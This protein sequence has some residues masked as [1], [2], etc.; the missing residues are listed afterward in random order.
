MRRRSISA[1]I[2]NAALVAVAAEA[3]GQS[4]PGPTDA[5]VDQIAT[6]APVDAPD[7]N[8]DA[9]IDGGDLDALTPIDVPL[10]PLPDG[11][12]V[13]GKPD[14]PAPCGYTEDLNDFVACQIDHD[15]NTQE[16]AVCFVLCDPTEPDCI[17]YDLGDAGGSILTCG[18]GCIGRLR[19]DARD[20]FETCAPL[21]ESAA[22]F[23]ARAA[24]LEA[25]A[26]DAF[27]A[28]ARDLD[29]HGASHLAKRAR[30]AA[31]DEVRHARVTARLA[32]K[33]GAPDRRRCR[34]TGT[35]ADRAPRA[36][37][38]IAIENAEEG[39]VRETFGAAIATWQAERAR[40]PDVRAAMR[41]IAREECEHAELGWAIADWARERLTPRDRARVEASRRGALAAMRRDLGN[42]LDD[43]S[44]EALGLPDRAQ[45]ERL[46][47]AV[48]SAVH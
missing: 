34:S 5:S 10:L 46:F 25:A 47:D 23:L 28:L 1:A 27:R 31:R 32:K 44:R 4:Q 24:T 20:A 18:P 38:A 40:D 19:R 2:R 36:L 13:T 35:I 7:A 45:A 9:T 17:Y 22:D 43:A 15:A 16:A 41:A 3:C 42:A 21:A 11:C 39:C 37:L 6:D 30:R 12:I 14:G 48:M 33:H 8:D 29:A 26:I